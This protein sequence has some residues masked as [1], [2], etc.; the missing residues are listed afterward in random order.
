MSGIGT[1]AA[2]GTAWAVC[3]TAVSGFQKSQMSATGIA[4]ETNQGSQGLNYDCLWRL[5]W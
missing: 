5:Y 3:F 1:N 2:L 4:A